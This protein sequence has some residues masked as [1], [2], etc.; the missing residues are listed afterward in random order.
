[1]LLLQWGNICS[2]SCWHYRS[3]CQVVLVSFCRCPQRTCQTCRMMQILVETFVQGCAGISLL[4]PIFGSSGN[5]IQSG[6]WCEQQVTEDV[7]PK[8][9]PPFPGRQYMSCSGHVSLGMCELVFCRMWITRGVCKFSLCTQGSL[10]VR[11][12]CSTKYIPVNFLFDFASS[13]LPLYR[14]KRA[15]RKSGSFGVGR[16]CPWDHRP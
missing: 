14:V 13:L 15:A 3:K 1:M 4:H 16:G 10:Y 12:E 9:P 2:E 5:N 7:L 6:G 8:G 11:L